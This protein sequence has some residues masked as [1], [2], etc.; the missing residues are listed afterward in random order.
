MSDTRR[1]DN[2]IMLREMAADQ[3]RRMIIEG[4]IQPG[5]KLSER[6]LGAKLGMS[7]TP[8]KE[9][10]R[11]LQ[12]EGLIYSV[13]RKGSYVSL[14]YKQRVLQMV[15]IRSAIEGTAAYFA[16]T[17]ATEDD[18]FCM[19]QAL[20]CAKR[21][22]DGT[23][24]PDDLSLEKCND[25]FHE[26]LRCA[27]KNDYLVGLIQNMRSVDKIIRSIANASIGEESH[28]AYREHQAILDAVKSGD[29]ALTEQLM[30]KHIRRV[31]TYILSSEGG[32]NW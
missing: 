1:V 30:I 20:A 24:A 16:C 9:A 14:S 28:R 4:Q 10:F 23:A 31:I 2:T 12:T 5:E 15:F 13:P 17:N 27:S 6:K 3:V 22:I 11:A 7:T 25:E 19:E 29:S 32:S 26:V 8:I 21:N 18:I